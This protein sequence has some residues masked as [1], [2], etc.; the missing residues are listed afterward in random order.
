MST[1][2]T[3]KV[4]LL[5]AEKLSGIIWK[6]EID[7]NHNLLFVE[8]RNQEEHQV[9]FTAIDLLTGK[10]NFN[11][12]R[13]EE[14][15]QIGMEGAGN[16]ML[17]LHGYDAVSSPAHKGII[18]VDGISGKTIW[19]NYVMAVDQFFEEG[20]M[21]FDTRL[22]PR[23]LQLINYET[24]AIMGP[25]NH[26]NPTNRTVDLIY[27]KAENTYPMLLNNHFTGTFTS[28]AMVADHQHSQ[29]VSLHAA[30]DNFFNQHL[31]ILRS[32][33]IIF[34]DLL[35]EH[36]QKLQ[37]EAFVMHKRKLVYIKNHSEIKVVNL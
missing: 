22:Q 37:P 2:S 6:L 13:T 4:D 24:G 7:S 12:L 34:Q 15:W 20:I 30:V 3:P 21:V 35:N 23:R 18:A 14:R 8:V 29:I 32:E 10:I 25:A 26:F 16:G 1:E 19:A 9:S 11:N 36:I 27:P 31:F 28:D 17:F 5:I 33:E